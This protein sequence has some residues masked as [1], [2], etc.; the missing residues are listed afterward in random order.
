MPSSSRSSRSDRHRSQ[1]PRSPDGSRSC[2]DNFSM[3]CAAS[4]TR[5]N[6]FA[7]FPSA[8]S[9]VA[10]SNS[11]RISLSDT[12]PAASSAT[13]AVADEIP[14]MDR[15][16][17]RHMTAMTAMMVMIFMIFIRAVARAVAH[18][19]TAGHR[20]PQGHA[21]FIDGVMAASSLA[22]G[23]FGDA[24]DLLQVGT[25]GTT[26]LSRVVCSVLHSS[27]TCEGPPRTDQKRTDRHKSHGRRIKIDGPAGQREA[28]LSSGH[29]T[30]NDIGGN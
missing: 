9:S 28:G 5:A 14:R 13:A 6:A 26:P 18:P 10:V 30:P 15:M 17:M 1:R 23:C 16:N 21:V 2:C 12:S 27:N 20:Q 3:P 22:W 24:L 29:P 25:Q 11:S 8:R 19:A 7:G 4:A